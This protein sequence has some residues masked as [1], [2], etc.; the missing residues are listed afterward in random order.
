MT[1]AKYARKRLSIEAFR[2]S[3]SMSGVSR[4]YL[5]PQVEKVH[6]KHAKN[7]L[8]TMLEHVGLWMFQ[9]CEPKKCPFCLNSLSCAEK[10]W[11]E[12]P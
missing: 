9:F 8:E 2:L 3:V 5:V 7:E 1:V 12:T 4:G 11:V 10:K 6:V